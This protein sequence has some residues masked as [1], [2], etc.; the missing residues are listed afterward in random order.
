[1]SLLAVEV[2]NRRI[3][4]LHLVKEG[5]ALSLVHEG[6]GSFSAA[7]DFKVLNANFL[8][9]FVRKHKISNCEVFLTVSDPGVIS[10]RNTLLPSM[11]FRELKPA[12]IWQAK[13]EGAL[14]QDDCLY[15]YDVVKEYT[16]AENA[17]KTAVV[18]SIVNQKELDG[19]LAGLARNGFE[20]KQ[21]NVS[22]LNYSKVL[23]A[24]GDGKISQAVLDI[25]DDYSTLAIYRHG[26]ML[27]SRVLGFSFEKAKAALNDPLFLGADAQNP[28]AGR[29]I[30][31]AFRLYGV[32]PQSV[33]SGEP[34]N[35][36][37]QFF[38]LMRPLIEGLVR[39]VRYSLTYFM[40]NLKEEKPSNL[41][42]AGYGAELKGL[43]AY[44]AKEL[45]TNTYIFSMPSKIQNK[46]GGTEADSRATVRGVGMI[47]GVLG[48]K[49]TFD[50]S[51]VEFKSKRFETAQ[52]RLLVLT[53]ASLAGLL[54]LSFFFMRLQERF[55]EKRLQIAKQH[56][57]TLGPLGEFS[58]SVFP[59]YYLSRE[60]DRAVVPAD[61]MLSLLGYLL[62]K[63]LML[64]HFVLEASRRQLRL[65][66]EANAG[67]NPLDLQTPAQEF[68]QRLKGTSFFSKIDGEAAGEHFNIIGEFRDD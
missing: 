8:R 22:V 20:V 47:G 19:H 2:G 43:E 67:M 32:Q 61:R 11:P 37:S 23:T 9:D 48:G 54:V 64:K 24:Y 60:I 49:E 14:G 34:Q 53:S 51:P 36:A 12:I 29:E 18:Y 41:F 6:G 56:L 10:L 57:Q 28:E 44:F 1:M 16:D 59:R 33:A 68:L 65:V 58:E 13:E 31:Q 35:R 46:L 4:V 38:T 25:G 62:P 30:E 39:E 7:E 50:F 63:E 66:L 17:K 5:G 55:L 27:Y 15:S 21:V 52:R 3:R 45:G 42:L 26:Q 40:T